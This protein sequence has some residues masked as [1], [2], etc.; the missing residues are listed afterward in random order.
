[1][2]PVTRRL[3]RLI[4]HCVKSQASSIVV[5]ARDTDVLVLLLAHFSKM[6][7]LDVWM[8]AGT[9]KYR[10]CI[11]IHTSAAQIDDNVLNSLLAFHSLT[12]S[13]TTYFLAGHSK[14]TCWKVFNDN[15]N[16]LKNLGD[17][18][19]SDQ[20]ANDAEVFICKVYNV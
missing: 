4:Q 1:M 8:K 6:S 19:L 20:T 13:D 15:H 11:P 2:K 10:K 3:T 14:K 7:C 5:V 18:E 17:G 12:G 16:L 9:A